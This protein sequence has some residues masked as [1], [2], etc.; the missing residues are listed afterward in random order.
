MWKSTIS[1]FILIKPDSA[2][3]WL[4]L[5]FSVF[6]STFTPLQIMGGPCPRTFVPSGSIWTSCSPRRPSCTCA[7]SLWTDTSPFETP[8]TTVASTPTR[9]LASRSWRC[10]RSQWVRTHTGLIIWVSEKQTFIL[11]GESVSV[12]NAARPQSVF[13]SFTQFDLLG[14]LQAHARCFTA[15]KETIWT[16]NTFQEFDSDVPSEWKLEHRSP[17]R[18]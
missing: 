6:P 2:Y 4:F 18:C 10:G 12:T 17:Q 3:F 14:V 8:S 9:R 15:V 7:P 1:S 16:M 5:C 11:N 13:K